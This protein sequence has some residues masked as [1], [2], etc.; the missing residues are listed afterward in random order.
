MKI[1]D[2]IFGC[3]LFLGGMAHALGAWS[4]LRA[5]P[6]MLLWSLAAAFAIFLLASIN[7]LRTARPADRAL[8]WI[9]FA[10]CLVWMGFAFAVGALRGSLLYL[11][12]IANVILSLILA[13]FSL[14]TARGN[15]A[16]AR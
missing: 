16:P 8:A 10:G 5:Q 13:G 2:R 15:A 1:A 4:A 14:R 6:A 11:P 9:S 7:L 12:A 3:I